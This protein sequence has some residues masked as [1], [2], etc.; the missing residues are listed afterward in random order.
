[1]LG[2]LYGISF[3]IPAPVSLSYPLLITP[4]IFKA[5]A[6]KK[7]FHVLWLPS[8]SLRI[9]SQ[10]LKMACK[11]PPELTLHCPPT[12]SPP[13]LSLAIAFQS[14]SPPS[15]QAHS[16]PRAFAPAIPSVWNALPQI[17]ADSLPNFLQASVFLPH[18]K[19]QA[20]MPGIHCSLHPHL[21][22]S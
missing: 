10:I 17:A 5:G 3:Q 19:P 4:I 8:T 16:H 15:C 9:K 6:I 12:S 13:T 18:M 21:F 22:S 20:L 1:M 14:Y 11:A 2:V 7:L